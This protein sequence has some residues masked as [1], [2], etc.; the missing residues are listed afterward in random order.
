MDVSSVVKWICLSTATRLLIEG[1]SEVS[2]ADSAARV[3]AVRKSTLVG[4]LVRIPSTAIGRNTLDPEF[5]PRMLCI[6]DHFTG[7]LGIGSVVER[8]LANILDDLLH[9]EGMQWI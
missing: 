2:L 4:E 6:S 9:G 7:L 5:E 8:V 3:G 1:Y